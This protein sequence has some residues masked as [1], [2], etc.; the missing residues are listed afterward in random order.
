[1]T[2]RKPGTPA[3]AGIVDLDVALPAGRITVDQMHASSGVSLPEILEITHC[4]EF[5]ALDPDEQAWELAV[6]AA[7]RVLE[8]TGTDPSA[9]S[10]VIYVGSGCWDQPFWSPA[11]KVADEL[12][13]TGAHC[14]EVVNF[15]NALM[16][17]V[18]IAASGLAPGSEERA[19]VVAGDRFSDVV[20]RTDPD[21]KGLFNFG[22]AAAAVLVGGSGHSFAYLASSARTD[23]SWCDHYAGEYQD[24]GIRVRRRGNRKGLSAAYTDNYV[25]LVD[26]TLEKIG[27]S[28]SDVRYLLV[29]QNDRNVQNRLLAALDLPP[30]RSV[31]NHTELGHMGCADTAI[32]LR[33]V[34]DAGALDDGDLVLL[35]AS[36]MGFSWSVTALEYRG[37]R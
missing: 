18:G 4:K 3:R 32:A 15:C 19:L 22:D 9:I 28:L 29:N 10:R 6:D 23:A 11:A 12:G 37:A 14:F 26:Q 34:W 27:R 1:M 2:D 17:G 20:D 16:T 7:D 33:Q 21:S 30:E 35:A 5:P 31:F 13:I 36:G 8:R 25:A 24:T